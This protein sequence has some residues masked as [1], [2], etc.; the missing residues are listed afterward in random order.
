MNE[1]QKFIGVAFIFSIIPATVDITRVMIENL[2]GLVSITTMGLEQVVGDNSSKDGASVLGSD[3]K[4][5]EQSRESAS[6]LSK[7]EGE[8][9]GRV[10]VGSGDSCTEDKED[11]EA[12]KET[13]EISSEEACAPKACQEHSSEHFKEKNQK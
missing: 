12:A 5:T 8:C 4:E 13:T 9:D 11:K 2:Q 10:E 7:H 1:K 6:V 3:V